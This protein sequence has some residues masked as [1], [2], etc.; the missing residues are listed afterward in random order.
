[1]TALLTVALALSLAA[2]AGGCR[3]ERA[4]AVALARTRHEIRGP[5]CTALLGL[6]PLAAGEHAARIAAIGH[7]LQ[8]AALALEELAGGAGRPRALRTPRDEAR[9]SRPASAAVDV[10]ALVTGAREAWQALAGAHGARLE[11]DAP[12]GLWARGE[13]LRLAQ[14]CANLV[15]NAAEHGGGA[16]GVRVRALGGAV[17]VE[18]TDDGPGLPAPV[19]ALVA[20]ARRR[21]GRRGH[22]LGVAAAVAARYGGRLAAKPSPRGA[23]LVL[24]LPAATAADRAAGP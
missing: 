22:G 20:A 9:P 6:E 19:D 4:N 23:R 10:G 13:P 24:E 21:T 7:E 1:M 8:R 5:L 3:R 15:A 17:R 12:R 2:L 14:A 16:V 11:V 18:V